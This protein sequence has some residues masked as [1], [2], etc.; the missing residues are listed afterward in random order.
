MW[1]ILYLAGLLTT[2]FVQLY[3]YLTIRFGLIDWMYLP[4]TSKLPAALVLLSAATSTTELDPKPVDTPSNLKAGVLLLSYG[5]ICIF[6]SIALKQALRQ[7]LTAFSS[8][9]KL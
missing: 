2:L 9:V 5:L 4:I 1:R 7:S 8:P 3:S 6:Q